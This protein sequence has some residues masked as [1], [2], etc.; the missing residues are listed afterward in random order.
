MSFDRKE[1]LDTLAEKANQRKANSAPAMRVLAAASVV[2]EKLIT[3]S[4]EWNRFL[5]Y[6]QGQIEKTR[7]QKESAHQKLADPSIWEP[8]QLNKLKSDLIAADA[9]ITALEWV[10]QLPKALIDGGADAQ[11]FL[12]KLDRENDKT[13][14]TAQS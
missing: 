8:Y 5:S 1:F 4:E 14:N 7:A 3:K 11:E 6:I 9:M 12:N 2:M 10:M 13:A